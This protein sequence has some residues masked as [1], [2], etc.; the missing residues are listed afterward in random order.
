MIKK[1]KKKTMNI[2]YKVEIL[3]YVFKTDSVLLQMF[4][5]DLRSSFHFCRYFHENIMLIFTV[6]F[7]WFSKDGIFF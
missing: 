4:S 3:P 5:Y 1:K 2:G 7:F 6:S